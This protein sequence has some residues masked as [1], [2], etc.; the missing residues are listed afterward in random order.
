[1]FYM[2]SVHA[3]L[4]LHSAD[5][6]LQQNINDLL[7]NFPKSIHLK[8]QQALIH[9]HLRGEAEYNTNSS[10]ISVAKPNS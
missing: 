8:S 10:Y 2:F 3:A 6:T 1:M 4:E 7:Q 5:E 9:Y